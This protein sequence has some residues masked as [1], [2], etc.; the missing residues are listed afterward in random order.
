M[1]RFRLGEVQGAIADGEIT[2]RRNDVE[3]LAFEQHAISGLHHGHRGAVG[4]QLRHH[5]LVLRIEM[6][7]E[8]ESHAIVGW[9]SAKKLCAGLQAACRGAYADD[10]KVI[11]PT[12][13]LTR[14]RGLPL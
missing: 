4:Q 8:D 6:L 13:R 11:C 14:R 2:A 7:H 5:A 10:R 12:G 3:V 9:Q 1:A